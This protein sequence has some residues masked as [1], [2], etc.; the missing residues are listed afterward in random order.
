MD[1]ARHKGKPGNGARPIA[2]GSLKNRLSR[3]P[4]RARSV[5]RGLTFLRPAFML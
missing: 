3:G 2:P 4:R 1:W 5:S